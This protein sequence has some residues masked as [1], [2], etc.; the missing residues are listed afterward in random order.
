MSDY[1]STVDFK[2]VK[3]STPTISY[4]DGAGTANRASDYKGGAFNDGLFSA[5]SVITGSTGL[6]S[7]LW[8]GGGASVFPTMI[9]F[10]ADATLTGA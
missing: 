9:H 10:V 6:G 2:V 5:S 3:R 7:F 4:W 8:Y 1:G